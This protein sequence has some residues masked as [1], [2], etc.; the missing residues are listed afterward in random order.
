MLTFSFNCTL[1]YLLGNVYINKARARQG[2][3]HAFNFFVIF[4]EILRV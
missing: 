2:F 3:S 1:K 4:K